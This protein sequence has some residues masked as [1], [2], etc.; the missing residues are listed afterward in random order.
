MN[1]E[2]HNEGMMPLSAL[3][4]PGVIAMACG[5]LMTIEYGDEEWLSVTF[6]RIPEAA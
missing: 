4:Q 1:G 2:E 6:T 5:Y 3:P